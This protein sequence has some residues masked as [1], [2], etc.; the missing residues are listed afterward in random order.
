MGSRRA[1][2]CTRKAALLILPLLIATLTA[3]PLE[4]QDAPSAR[5]SQLIRQNRLEDAEKQLWPVLTREPE[6]AWALRTLGTIRLRQ[7]RF[8]EAEALFQKAL[9]LNTGD[10]EACRGLG[11]V[12]TLRGQLD[13]AIDRYS[14]C[15]KIAPADVDSNTALAKLYEQTGDYAQSLE[16][17]SHI[18]ATSRPPQLLPVLASD[19]FG[20]KDPDKIGPLIAAVLRYK[21]THLPIVLEFDAILVRNGYVGDAEHLL[22]AA[23]PVKPSAEYLRAKS[24]VREAQG[25]RPEARKLLAQ[26][27]TLQPE[28]FDLLFDSARLAAQD[29]QWDDTVK[30]LRHADQVRPDRPEVLLKLTLALLKTQRRVAAVAVAHKLVTVQPDNPDNEY[31]LASALFSTDL[32]EEADPIARKL[33]QKRPDDANAHLL[34]GSVQ[35]NTGDIEGARR[36]FERCLELDPNKMVDARY[37]LAQIAE[38]QGDVSAARDQ[39]EKVVA[40]NP[41]HAAGQAELG[42]LQLRMGDVQEARAALEKAVKLRPEVSQSHYQLGLVYRRLGLQDQASAQMATYE[43]LR[44]AEDDLRRRESGLP[45]SDAASPQ[46]H[47]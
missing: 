21:T 35:F 14:N 7:N 37:Y 6:Q 2:F 17:A 8:P 3:S 11:E 28:S 45:K 19:Y 18:V 16:A 27:L 42:M 40:A 39:L 44:Q 41:D 5:V 25:R 32:F 1:Q 43:K 36:S 31:V 12:Y 13:K 23:K 4:A 34:L 29:N 33:V 24:R 38:R 47:P 22:E 10:L 20:M 9:A 26:A 46:S 15:V 30:F